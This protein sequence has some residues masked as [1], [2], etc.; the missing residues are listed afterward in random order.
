MADLA[1]SCDTLHNRGELIVNL[2][3][4]PRELLMQVAAAKTLVKPTPF[5]IE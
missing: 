2:R 3:D 5:S 4:R 1:T